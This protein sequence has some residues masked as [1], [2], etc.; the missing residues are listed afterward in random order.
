MLKVGRSFLL[1]FALALFPGC[2]TFKGAVYP[3]VPVLQV[4]KTATAPVID[5]KLDDPAWAKAAVINGLRPSLKKTY[6]AQIDQ[7]PTTIRVL[8]DE[9]F[10]YVAYACTDSEIY[11]SGTL[12]HDDNLYTED[13]CE[14]FLDGL[15]D[16]R[17]VVEI[18]ANSQG[19]N[20]DMMYVFTGTPEYTPERRLTAKF[21]DQNRWGFREW[22]MEGL[23][24]AAA[25]LVRDGKTVGWS[26]EM[27]I[28]AAVIVKRHGLKQFAPMEIRANFMRYDW[29]VNP[30]TGKRNMLHMNWSP[31]LAGCPHISQA[32]MGRLILVQGE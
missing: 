11:C 3:D 24:T 31:V 18:Q 2:S 17:Q 16:G 28:P 9:N 32:A 8:W 6:Q 12:K 14:I 25:P 30:K 26:V 1:V 10:L 29:P 20:L 5:G 23:S 7:V 4:P 21:C 15:G 19:L 13:V 27:A 22:T